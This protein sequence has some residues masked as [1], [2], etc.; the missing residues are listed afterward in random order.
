M[1]LGFLTM[2]VNPLIS[3]TMVKHRNI[4]RI[5][6]VLSFAAAVVLAFLSVVITDDKEIPNGNLIMCAQFLT[7][8]AT[9]FGVDYKFREHA[10]S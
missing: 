3:K 4:E 1:P 6:A 9:I 8:T 2:T 5:I 10:Q 7:L